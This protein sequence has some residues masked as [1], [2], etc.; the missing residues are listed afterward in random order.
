MGAGEACSGACVGEASCKHGVAPPAPAHA[1]AMSPI[2][3]RHV[4]A[5]RIGVV[6]SGPAGRHGAM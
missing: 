4:S 2:L 6:R 5:G 1:H 3:R